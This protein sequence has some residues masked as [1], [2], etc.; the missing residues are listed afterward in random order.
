MKYS[1]LQNHYKNFSIP[2]LKKKFGFANDF[3][4]PKI[5]KICVN[6]SIKDAVT[7]PKSIEKIYDEIMLI[8]G[9]KPV[10]T[11]A[12]KSISAFK[13]RE[14]MK[15]G[16]KVT[17]R[18]KIM[19]EFLDRLVTI[20]LPR[21][22]DFNGFS[23]KQFDGNGNFSLGIKEQI[24]FPEIDYNKVDKIRGMNIVINTS[25]CKDKEAKFLLETFNIPFNN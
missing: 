22:R 2:Q 1:R 20:A 25:S 24:I 23:S 14:G 3:Q 11:S 21:V 15:I 13:L 19:Y 8:T 5:L 16:C 4:I 10:I 6:V 7:N 17:L 9:Q 18:K 12:R